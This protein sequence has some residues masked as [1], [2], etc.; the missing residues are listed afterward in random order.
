MLL[1]SY[2][3]DVNSKRYI[4]LQC[5]LFY[6]GPSRERDWAWNFYLLPSLEFTKAHSLGAIFA[7]YRITFSILVWVI[8]IQIRWD[9][10]KYKPE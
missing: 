9:R 7:S 2:N 8:D 1:F 5:E 10:R 3:Q 6:V 4:Q